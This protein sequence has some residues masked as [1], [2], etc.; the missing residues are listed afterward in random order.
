[1]NCKYK[2][3]CGYEICMMEECCDFDGVPLTN[4]D[5]IRAMSDEELAEV[6]MCPYGSEPDICCTKGTCLECCEEWLQQPA[7]V[8]GKIVPTKTLE[9]QNGM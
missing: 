3:S 9:D 7:E 6:I 2:D 8:A 1:M 5:L 4:A